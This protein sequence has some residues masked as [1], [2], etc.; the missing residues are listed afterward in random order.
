MA[1]IRIGHFDDFKGSNTLLI[2]CDD[3]GLR[4]LIDLIR[5]VATSGE[6]SMLERRPDVVAHG[7]VRVSLERSV[8]D[9]GLVAA[10]GRSFAWR[11]SSEGWTDIAA[12]LQAMQGTGPC[13]Q[14]LD[15]P[16]DTLQVTAAI[17]EYGEAWWNNHAR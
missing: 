16:T 17:G 7:A 15:G 4:S 1:P 10:D 12:K 6:P 9:V 2:E 3:E 14:Y 5:D 13:H 11:R 8:D